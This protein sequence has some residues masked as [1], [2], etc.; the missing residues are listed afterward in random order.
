M[1]RA[2]F[3]AEDFLSTALA[4]AAER[5][6][7]AI[8]VG[9]ITERLSAP[10]GSFY[11]RF[12]SRDFLMIELWLRLAADFQQ[13]ID[14]ALDAGDPLGAALHTPAWA[15][16]HMDEA[17]VLLL[18]RRDD[19]VQGEGPEALREAVSAEAE[20]TRAAIAKF[21]SLVFGSTAE[22][23]LSRAEF[24]LF[25]VPLAAVLQ[26]LNRREP[27]PRIVDDL[28]KTPSH[29]LVAAYFASRGADG[30]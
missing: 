19:F 29:A 10:T 12:T 9:S 15:R 6:P 27:P 5:G 30:G 14:T 17:R 11:H 2:R 18:Y 23:E 3:V 20:R 26:P 1:A 8:T 22:D 16:A 28:I 21:A 24:L 4:I 13:G 25:E 7:P